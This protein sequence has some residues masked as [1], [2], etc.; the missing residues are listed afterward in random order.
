MLVCPAEMLDL[1]CRE[2]S[3]TAS[4]VR[5]TASSPSRGRLAALDQAAV[6]PSPVEIQQ[7]KR[8]LFEA[9]REVVANKQAARAR[10]NSLEGESHASR[11]R[12][13]TAILQLLKAQHV[14]HPTC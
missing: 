12:M 7:L 3:D 13:L 5:A 9:W 10:R 14:Q 6:G 1:R 8:E 11:C 4:G 2:P